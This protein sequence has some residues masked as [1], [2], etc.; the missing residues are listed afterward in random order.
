MKANISKNISRRDFA[1]GSLLASGGILFPGSLSFASAKARNLNT[2][3]LFV[4]TANGGASLVDSF[5]PLNPSTAHPSLRAYRSDQLESAPGSAFICPKNIPYRLGVPVGGQN[6]MKDFLVEHSNSMAVVT[7]EATS[8]N[9]FVAAQRAVNGNGVNQG[10]TLTE[11]H[12]AA[13]GQG[14]L[15]PN[16]NMASGGYAENG[17]DSALPNFAR[18]EPI[19]NPLNFAFATHSYLG[20]EKKMNSSDVNKMRQLRGMF[21]S[22]SPESSRLEKS[23]MV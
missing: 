6:S 3:L 13:S 11:A 20:L 4:V 9:H 7:H 22:R 19:A 12:A 18:S 2:K 17:S 16:V 8:V 21:E 5:L 23:E 10:R 14:L 15:F 1:R